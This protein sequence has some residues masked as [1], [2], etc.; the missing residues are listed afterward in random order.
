[1][2]NSISK[3]NNLTA[4]RH[5]NEILLNDMMRKIEITESELEQKVHELEEMKNELILLNN[6]F[7]IDEL[8]VNNINIQQLNKKIKNYAHAINDLVV[9][10][11]KIRKGLNSFNRNKTIRKTPTLKAHINHAAVIK[12]LNKIYEIAREGDKK[13]D[14]KGDKNV[15]KSDLI[16]KYD[17]VIKELNTIIEDGKSDVEK[18]Q[19]EL[20]YI[21]EQYEQTPHNTGGKSKRKQKRRKQTRRKQT[22]RK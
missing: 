1:M 21:H 12:E 18:I 4:I 14:K 22:R 2:S 10:K 19:S 7:D 11:D 9:A 20:G 8:K 13:G 17:N 15:D 16:K 5:K 6:T 3:S